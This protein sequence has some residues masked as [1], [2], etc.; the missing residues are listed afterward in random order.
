MFHRTSCIV[1]SQDCKRQEIKLKDNWKKR[2]RTVDWY[3]RTQLRKDPTVCGTQ[4]KDLTIIYTKRAVRT[5][6][7]NVWYVYDSLAYRVIFKWLTITAYTIFVRYDSRTFEIQ[8]CCH[9]IEQIDQA[10]RA[11]RVKF[12]VRQKLSDFLEEGCV[13]NSWVQ[14]SSSTYLTMAELQKYACSPSKNA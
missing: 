13:H 1:L 5:S 12:L 10:W 3:H 9:L 14:S 4:N 7:T 11:R 8:T 2:Q 6:Q